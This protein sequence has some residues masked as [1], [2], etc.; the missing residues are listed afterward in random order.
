MIRVVI[1][2]FGAVLLLGCGQRE[3]GEDAAKSALSAATGFEAQPVEVVDAQGVAQLIAQRDGKV[4][5][6]NLWATYCQPCVEEFPDIVKLA[7]EM[8]GSDVE[9]VAISFDYPD[10]VESLIQPF[11]QDNKVTFRVLVA[12]VEDPDEFVNALDPQWN[13]A[14]PTTI[15]YDANG[16]RQ[17]FLV[18]KRAYEVFKKEL[19]KARQSG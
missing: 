5:F 17:S 7:D 15:M 16:K 11:L 6:L 19:A 1:L 10:E 8:S 9:F 14:L 4:L 2:L 18:G 3:S 12:D 13:G